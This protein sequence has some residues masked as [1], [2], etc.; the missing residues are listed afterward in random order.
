MSSRTYWKNREEEQ[1]KKSIKDEAKYAKEIERI[2]TNMMDEIQKEINGFYVRYAKKEGI[3]IAEA[4]KRASKLDMEEYSRKA[5]KYVKE[6]NFSDA[7][8]EEMRLYNM[9]MKVNRLEM[10][11]ARMG[12]ELVSGFDELQKFFDEK[13]TDR[14]LEEFERQAG[15]LG[16]SVL[17]NEKKAHAIVNASF[18]NAKFSDRIWM[19][20]DMMKAE[21][22]KLLQQGLIRGKHPRDLAR[23]LKKLFGVSQYNAERLMITELARV[24]SE[25]QKQSFERNG[26]EYYEY[27]ACG[28]VDV[29]NVC[30]VL[31][32]KHFKVKDMMPGENAPPMHPSCHCSVAAWED[33]EEYEAW[34]DYLDSGGTTEEWE[35]LKSKRVQSGGKNI[36][37]G[38]WYKPY[39]VEDKKDNAASKE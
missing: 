5:A 23:H 20:Q 10:L 13:L 3:T 9:T 37:G 32:G 22:S 31:D 36:T 28:K 14:T 2:Y 24:Q 15:I 30:K 34:L 19:Y 25:A 38:K 35:K 39:D 4:K 18:H 7:A 1:R 6:K 21:L 8:N 27:I 17:Q 12:L 29:C 26:F 33:N 11:K 16:K